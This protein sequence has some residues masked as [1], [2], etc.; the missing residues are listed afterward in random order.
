MPA[1]TYMADL[2]PFRE[3]WQFYAHPCREF[4]FTMSDGFV[5]RFVAFADL[6]EF[7]GY[8]LRRKPAVIHAGP[9]YTAKPVPS[10]DVRDR[11]TRAKRARMIDAEA[12]L[13]QH[14]RLVEVLSAY[15][16][17]GATAKEVNR[18]RVER[19]EHLFA[20]SDVAEEC[21]VEKATELRFDVDVTDYSEVLVPS[22]DPNSQEFRRAWH[23]LRAGAKVSAAIH[24]H[25]KFSALCFGYP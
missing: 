6:G 4:A 23:V 21:N 17:D 16:D 18:M 9:I 15:G 1:T 24:G 8:I 10:C 14:R 11:Q 3:L 20:V 25:R 5:V 2:F 12:Y 13:A 19:I 22:S 7:R